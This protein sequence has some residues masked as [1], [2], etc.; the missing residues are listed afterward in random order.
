M[1]AKL[2]KSL[3]MGGKSVAPQ[4]GKTTIVDLDKDEFVRLLAMGKVAKPSADEL[5]LAGAD[6]D[7]EDDDTTQKPAPVKK[8]AKPA[9]TGAKTTGE[10][11]S[12]TDSSTITDL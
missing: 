3:R 12:V 5:K 7:G 6:D 4:D 10:A 1:K 8:T 9:A 11:Q 2:L